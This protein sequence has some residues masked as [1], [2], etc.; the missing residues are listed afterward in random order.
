MDVNKR[1]LVVDDEPLSVTAA[2]DCL[3]DAGYAAQYVS[4]GRQAWELL[5][6]TP[7]AFEAIILDR[8][9]PELDGITLLMK[10]KES[11]QLQK[12]PVIIQTAS[13][14]TE[15]YLAALEAGAYDLIYK[16]LERNFLLYVINNAVNEA[17]INQEDLAG[18][19]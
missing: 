13:E 11:P 2:I 8:V 6:E 12:I 16:P 4:S 7:D 15:S 9:M 10:I 3:Q 5:N 17:N 18:A 14:N 1:I 19:L